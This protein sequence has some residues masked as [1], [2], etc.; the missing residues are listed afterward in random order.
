[1]K[2]VITGGMGF[3]GSHFVELALQDNHQI[4]VLD[5]MTYA[6]NDLNLSSAV[7]DKITLKKIDIS[8]RGSLENSLK[9]FEDTD[10]FVNFAAESHVD[11]SIKDSSPFLESNIKGTVNLLELVKSGFAKKMIQVSTDEVYGSA[12]NGSWNED[13]PLAPRSPYSASK[14]SA[15]FFCDAYRNTHGVN[16]VISRCANNYGSRQS[17]EKFIPTAISSIL[18]NENIGVYGDGENR[19]EWLH[20]LDHCRAIYLLMNASELKY[21]YYNIGGEELTNNQL[22]RKLID[23]S[24]K[25]RSSIEFVPDRLGH[26][27]R[28]SV[29]DG[30]IRQELGWSPVYKLHE[31]LLQT[32]EWY[33]QNPE[34]IT[35]SKE[36]LAK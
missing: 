28:Y 31:G 25:S 22:A 16:V 17:V 27:F 18:A 12:A 8:D 32:Y 35:E 2:I 36:R 26:D 20:V 5:K 11:R 19:R 21:S 24:N 34:W 13:S 23:I 4:L 30:R 1:M 14:A 7:R 33:L 10:C 6:A 15:E 9:G 3:I 29:D